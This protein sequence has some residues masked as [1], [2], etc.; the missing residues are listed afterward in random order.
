MDKKMSCTHICFSSQFLCAI[1]MCATVSTKQLETECEPYFIPKIN[2][3][4]LT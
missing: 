3:D 4:R 1:P 2:I